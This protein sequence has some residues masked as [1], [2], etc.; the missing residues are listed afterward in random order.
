MPF[1]YVSYINCVNHNVTERDQRKAINTTIQR[2]GG[3]NIHEIVDNYDGMVGF[4][5]A[6]R[7]AHKYG[8]VLIFYKPLNELYRTTN[9]YTR[10][11]LE[12]ISVVTCHLGRF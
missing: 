9:S 3:I 8:A 12:Q 2:R 6:V 4:N 11:A 1:G 7:I 10:K 5:E